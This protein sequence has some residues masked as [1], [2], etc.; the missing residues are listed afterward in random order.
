VHGLDHAQAAP[1]WR[2]V[3]EDDDGLSFGFRFRDFR[4][5]PRE[6]GSVDVDFLEFERKQE[7]EEKERKKMGSEWSRKR[8]V[9][10]V[11]KN[12]KKNRKKKQSLKK[13]ART[14]KNFSFLTF[15]HR[16]AVGAEPRRRHPQQDRGPQLGPPEVVLPK[17]GTPGLQ[18]GCVGRLGRGER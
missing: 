15:M 5:E 7:K 3:R 13:N 9:L 1:G 8:L 10:G 14:K 17:N 6:L 18:V 2:R 11:A 4:L 16:V 12:E